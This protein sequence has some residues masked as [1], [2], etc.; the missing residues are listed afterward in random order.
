MGGNELTPDLL[1]RAYRIGLFPMA[2]SADAPGLHWMDPPRR[3]VLPLRGLHIS[4]SLR[5][6]VARGRMQVSV[7]RDF[8]GVMRACA[9]RPQTWINGP[10]HKAYGALHEIGAAHSLEVW[11]DGAL[12]GGIYGVQIGS[13]FCGESMFSARR[14]ASK[15][16]LVWLVH[17]LVA[18]GFT[19]FDTQYLTPHLASLGAVEIPRA[20]YHRLLAQ[21]L[22]RSASFTPPDYQPS[23][24]E[25]ASGVSAG[26]SAGISGATGKGSDPSAIRQLKTQT[27]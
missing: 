5:A 15:T 6:H 12:A 2:E 3:G 1:L 22:E 27:S 26:V 4:R 24:S 23:A 10:I 13:A 25:V 17:R 16:A 21:A 20:A 7:N 8:A 11:Q 18:G 9:A 19:L 14:D